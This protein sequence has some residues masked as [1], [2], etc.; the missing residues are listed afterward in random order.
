MSAQRRNRKRSRSG[1]SQA[2]AVDIWRAV[3]A[4]DE[5]EPIVPAVDPT[6]LIRSLGRPPLPGQQAFSCEWNGPR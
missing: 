5:P 4:A 3:P 6:A 1:K 2:Q